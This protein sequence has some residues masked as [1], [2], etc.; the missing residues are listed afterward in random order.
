M[1]FFQSNFG[2]CLIIPE[3]G[4]DA[5]GAAGAA[6]IKDLIPKK[7]S[8]IC[9]ATGT[10][11]TLA[12]LLLSATPDQKIVSVPVLKGMIDIN[13]RL[14]FLSGKEDIS[15]NLRILDGYDFG[16]YAKKDS[17]LIDFMNECWLKY[18]LPLDFVYTAKMMYGVIDSIKNNYFKE[19]SHILCLHTGGL[20]GNKSLPLKSLLF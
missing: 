8:H 7:Y 14:K 12:G 20:Q 16:G 15:D 10:A 6:L 17:S 3:G 18:N 19:G 11:T 1:A 9:T 5:M 2:N 4:Y 13:E